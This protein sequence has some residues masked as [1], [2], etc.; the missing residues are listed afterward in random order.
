MSN[1]VRKCSNKCSDSITAYC[2]ARDQKSLFEPQHFEILPPGARQPYR[3]RSPARL[4]ERYYYRSCRNRSRSPSHSRERV[5]TR[6]SFDRTYGNR[7]DNGMLSNCVETC[8][9][10][11]HNMGIMT[12]NR[13]AIQQLLQ[14][15]EELESMEERMQTLREQLALAVSSSRNNADA[16]VGTRTNDTSDAQRATSRMHP[17]TSQGLITASPIS[18]SDRLEQP[19]VPSDA[20]Y[21]NVMPPPP[22]SGTTQ[23]TQGDNRRGR[24]PR[25]RNHPTGTRNSGLTATQPGTQAPSTGIQPPNSRA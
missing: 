15:E 8:K 24:N 20:V 9:S 18:G 14:L 6:S 19:L 16:S 7:A 13:T 22:S 4:Y 3:S 23:P 10:F 12:K 25:R 11:K 5:L 21:G 2:A 17:E 1:M